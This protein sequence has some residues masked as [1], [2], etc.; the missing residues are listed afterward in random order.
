LYLG[1]NYLAK[2]VSYDEI[3]EYLS[4]APELKVQP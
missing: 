4:G 3:R 1:Q 2:H